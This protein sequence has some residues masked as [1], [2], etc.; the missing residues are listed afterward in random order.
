MSGGAAGGVEHPPGLSRVEP[1]ALGALDGQGRAAAGRYEGEVGV[2]LGG[3]RRNVGEVRVAVAQG[4][5]SAATS[6]T[7]A[8]S[9]SRSCGTRYSVL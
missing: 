8:T 7:V 3:R 4:A 9:F 1:D 5:S 6:S 2:A